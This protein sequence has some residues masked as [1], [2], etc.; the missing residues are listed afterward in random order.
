MKLF[1]LNRAAGCASALAFVAFVGVVIPAIVMPFGANAESPRPF[2]TFYVAPDGNDAWDGSRGRP[3]ATLARAQAAARESAPNM[4]GDIV[5]NVR[6]GTYRLA[7]T[8]KLTAAD[9]GTNGHRVI[10]QAYGY[11]TKRQEDVVISGGRPITGWTLDDPVKNIWKAAA[12]DLETRQLYVNGQRAFRA[13]IPRTIQM[14]ETANGYTVTGSEHLSWS[15]PSDIELVYQG[16]ANHH[17]HPRCGVAAIVGP[18]I[19]MDQ[20]CWR[21]FQGVQV[22]N[23]V[24]IFAVI[25]RIPTSFE[26]SKSFLS[27][28]G[29]FYLDRSVS[30]GHVLYYIPRPGE[31]LSQAEVIAPVLELL[32]HGNGIAE[33]PVHDLLYDLYAVHAGTVLAPVHDITFRGFTFAHATWLHPSTENGYIQYISETYENGDPGT[34]SRSFAARTTPGRLL[35]HYCDRITLEGNRFEK[36]GAMA[37]EINGGSENIVRGN[38]ITDTSSGGILVGQTQDEHGQ[39]GS[40]FPALAR[41]NV[42]D[43]NWIHD[44]G[45]EYFGATGVYA[46]HATNVV[47]SHNQINGLP[48]R[49]IYVQH[50]TPVTGVPIRGAKVLNNLIFDVQMKL[51]DGGGIYTVENQSANLSGGSYETG[52]LVRGN[53]IHDTDKGPGN[54]DFALYSDWGSRWITW[55]SNFVYN[56]SGSAFRFSTPGPGQ[57]QDIRYLNNFW[58]HN[59]PGGFGPQFNITFEGNTV[60]PRQGTEAACRATPACLAILE[61]AGLEPEYQ[62]LL[63]T[64]A[65]GGP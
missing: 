63:Q 60:L 32:V 14:Q 44:V 21:R 27:K 62:H 17:S 24:N 25:N 56:T 20:P 31:D 1:K 51:A 28:P 65:D 48:D 49:G 54:L 58:I 57:N 52:L 42:I 64:G 47:I 4:T 2:A 19:V 5:I 8:L 41:D 45:A 33:A 26:N 22:L 50:E 10:Y 38:V 35:F 55:E 40:Q 61:G 7:E 3:L 46:K 30:G 15:N 43:N 53:V 9:S 29:T 6:G 36:L 18:T 16:T 12:G 23:V 39:P 37:L 59:N 34:Y 11:G 13:S